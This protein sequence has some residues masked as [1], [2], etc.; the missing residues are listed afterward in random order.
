MTRVQSLSIKVTLYSFI[1][2]DGHIIRN[3]IL[4]KLYENPNNI[5]RL[6]DI[7]LPVDPPLLG[8]CVK[9]LKLEH[10]SEVKEGDKV[11]KVEFS[12]FTSHVLSWRLY[13]S[14]EGILN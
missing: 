6:G 8:G 12:R 3:K 1:H 11:I 13:K 5:P 7:W 9:F 10:S 14:E 2:L 4:C